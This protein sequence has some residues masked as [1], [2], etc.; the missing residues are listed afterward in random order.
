MWVLRGIMG[1]HRPP[2]Q[3]P[4]EDALLIGFFIFLIF[5]NYC[6][7]MWPGGLFL[8]KKSSGGCSVQLLADNL[9]QFQHRRRTH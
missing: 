1:A 6:I 7:L 9:A 2:Y 8:K 4:L 3:R 5:F